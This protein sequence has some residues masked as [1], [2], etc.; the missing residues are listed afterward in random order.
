MQ[1]LFVR[2]R[3][4][5]MVNARL[6]LAATVLHQFLRNIFCFLNELFVLRY[7]KRFYAQ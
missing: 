1:S 2:I 5:R 3:H 6:D 4:S 7:A